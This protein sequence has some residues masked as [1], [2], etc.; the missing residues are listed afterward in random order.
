M[1]DG[2]RATEREDRPAPVAVSAIQLDRATL[3][4]IIAGVTAQLRSSGAV[5]GVAAPEETPPAGRRAG[6]AEETPPIEGKKRK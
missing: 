2:G 5:P 3:D 1:A 6:G 4:T